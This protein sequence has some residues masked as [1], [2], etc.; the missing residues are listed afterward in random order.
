VKESFVL[1]SVSL[2]DVVAAS[3]SGRCSS[4]DWHGGV[5]ALSRY[6]APHPLEVGRINFS[7]FI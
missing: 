1:L 3:R 2:L 6:N 5:N 7:Y 4:N